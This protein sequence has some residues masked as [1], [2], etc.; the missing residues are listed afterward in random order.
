[1]KKY[2]S[3]S[4][5]FLKLFIT[6]ERNLDKFYNTIKREYLSREKSI[7]IYYLFNVFI[8]SPDIKDDKEMEVKSNSNYIILEDSR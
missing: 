3:K 7:G 1:M 8:D 4:D 6:L 5:I 2:Y